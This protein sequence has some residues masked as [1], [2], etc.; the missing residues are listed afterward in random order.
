MSG[1]L[2]LQVTIEQQALED[3][4]LTQPALK[5]AASQ[6]LTAR[7]APSDT[8]AAVLSQ[9]TSKTPQE[10][11]AIIHADATPA[12]KPGAKPA[13]VPAKAKPKAGSAAA[14]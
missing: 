12:G 11:W 2:P 4:L 9:L 1:S 7:A 8:V 13:A 14:A 10:L 5:A 6:L 3:F